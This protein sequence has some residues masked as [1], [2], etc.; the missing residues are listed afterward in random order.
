MRKEARR[1]AFTLIELLVV[2][3]IIAILAGLLLPAL[4]RAKDKAQNTVDISNSKQVALASAMY[5]TDANDQVAHPTWGGGLSG[6]DGWAYATRNPSQN[7]KSS[8][9]LPNNAQGAIGDCNGRDLNSVQF[10]NQLSFFKIGQLGPNLSGNYQV[11]WCP[12]DV[13]IRNQSGLQKQNW[14][15]RSIKVTSYCWNGV[16]G[17]YVGPK[18][19]Q[20]MADAG[21]TYK[22]SDFLP[23]DW[24]FWEQNEISPPGAAAGFMFNDAGNNPETA[25]EVLSLRHSGNARWAAD[26]S[27]GRLSQRNLPGGAMIGTFGGTAGFVRWST[28]FDQI[29]RRPPPP[30]NSLLCGPPYR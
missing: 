2:I 23:T 21:K 27:S 14:M 7:G 15:G 30:L 26:V 28:C 22:V 10:S 25:G 11:M 16:I 3:A 9:S 4:S 12:K 13:A 17:S 8:P 29:N 5:S 19:S 6:P 24:Q 18:R 20:S 1:R